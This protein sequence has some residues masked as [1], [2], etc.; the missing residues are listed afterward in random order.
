MKQAPVSAP[1]TSIDNSQAR[2]M[3]FLSHANPEDNK[4]TLWLAL[5]LD[6]PRK[7]PG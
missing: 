2:D 6:C 1:A 7:R 3:I 4:F 5:Q